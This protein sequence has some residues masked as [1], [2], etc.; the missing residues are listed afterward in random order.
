M[1]TLATA[2]F[3]PDFLEH[4]AQEQPDATCWIYGDRTWTF[5]EAWESVRRTASALREAGLGRGDRVAVLEKNN[6]A[7]LQLVLGGSLIGAATTVVN[8]RLA[9][10]EL[11]Y[12]LNDSGARLAVVGADQ[13]EA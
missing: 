11:D 2:T 6:P 9:G 3:L 12:V 13:Q 10:D 5:A 8:W 7:I 1:S 4:Q